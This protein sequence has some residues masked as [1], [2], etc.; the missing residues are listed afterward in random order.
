M[1]PITPFAHILDGDPADSLV[2]PARNRIALLTGQ[3]DP[4][5]TALSPEQSEFLE[6][7]AP[8]GFDVLPHGFPFSRASEPGGR[9]RRPHLFRASLNNAHQTMAAIFSGRFRTI[10]ATRLGELLDRTS[11]TLILVT[12]SCGLQFV[13]AAWPQLQASAGKL[14]IVA[15]GPASPGRLAVPR[16]LLTAVRGNSDI[17][18]RMLY[19]GRIGHAVRCG[20]LDYWTSPET[21][22]LVRALLAA[23]LEHIR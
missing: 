6:A 12:G 22:A 16:P 4:S 3:S 9:Y 19:R 11:G 7:I 15:L 2:W 14:H 20:H 18:S 17:W 8:P 1:V 13:N 21:I 10:V 5:N 23:K